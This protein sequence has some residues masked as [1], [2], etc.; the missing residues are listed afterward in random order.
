M[1]AVLGAIL[2]VILAVFGAPLAFG[3]A[4]PPILVSFSADGGL[5]AGLLPFFVDLFGGYVGGKLGEPSQRE[6]RRLG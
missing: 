3:V 2:G 1:T 6:A 5:A 4:L